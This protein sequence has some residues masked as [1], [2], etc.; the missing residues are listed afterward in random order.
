[1]LRALLGIALLGSLLPSS[2]GKLATHGMERCILSVVMVGV[3]NSLKRVRLRKKECVKLELEGEEPDIACLLICRALKRGSQRNDGWQAGG[4]LG[5][6]STRLVTSIS[7]FALHSERLLLPIQIVVVDYNPPL[8]SPSLERQ[9]FHQY[10]S[11]P[12]QRWM[13]ATLTF[14]TVPPAVHRQVPAAGCLPG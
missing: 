14:V 4:E 13:Y 11:V 12:P 7:S 2:G 3:R 9:F 6:F 5:N 1:M 10:F 8:D